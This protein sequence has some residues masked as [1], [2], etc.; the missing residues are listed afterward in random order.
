MGFT[1]Y[2]R[3][4]KPVRGDT[5]DAIRDAAI[6]L[7]GG[8]TWLSCEPVMFFPD[9]PDGKLMGGVKPN[10]HPH[11]DDAAAGEREGLPD[12]TLLDALNV[13]CELSR[14]FGVDWSFSHDHDPGPIGFIR[15]GGCEPGLRD[16]VEALAGLGDAMGDLMDEFGNFGEPPTDPRDDSDDEGDGPPILPFRPKGG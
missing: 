16:Q 9:Q 4:T 6:P 7:I 10:F 12:G 11:P 2:Y 13:L 3:S 1:V 5:A 14:E 8:R 15:A